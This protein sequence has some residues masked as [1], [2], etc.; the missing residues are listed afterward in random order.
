MARPDIGA[1]AS[2]ISGITQGAATGFS[3]AEMANERRRRAGM[4]EREMKLKEQTAQRGTPAAK[5]V[6]NY[7]MGTS[8]VFAMQRRLQKM[9]EQLATN[10]TPELDAQYQKLSEV[11]EGLRDGT[12]QAFDFLMSQGVDPNS[13]QA[14][15][16]SGISISGFGQPPG[17]G[18]MQ[19][20][21]APPAVNLPR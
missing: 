13:P 15:Q 4:D 21:G 1:I 11:Y 14:L 17:A 9:Q 2:G 7:H 12:T 10:P 20:G 18:G 19:S 6:L 16:M 8:A 5:S 3:L